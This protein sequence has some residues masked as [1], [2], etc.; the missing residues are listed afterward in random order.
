MTPLSLGFLTCPVGMPVLPLGVVVYGFIFSV[1]SFLSS[2]VCRAPCPGRLGSQ[3]Q[4]WG[5]SYA[6]HLALNS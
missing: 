1:N 3:E 4:M 5:F 2:Y 6:E